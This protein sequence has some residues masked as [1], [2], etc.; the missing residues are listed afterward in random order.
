MYPTHVKPSKYQPP[1]AGY[2]PIQVI[3]IDRFAVLAPRTFLFAGGDENAPAR[4]EGVRNCG[5]HIFS[6]SAVAR[7]LALCSGFK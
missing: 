3:P 1:R 6:D 4:F 5:C 2:L 7:C